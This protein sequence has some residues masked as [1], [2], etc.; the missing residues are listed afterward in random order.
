L[1][2]PLSPAKAELPEI[3]VP[4]F[5]IV[6]SFPDSKSARSVKYRFNTIGQYELL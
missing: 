6:A 4:I 3:E 5:G 1:G 2:Y